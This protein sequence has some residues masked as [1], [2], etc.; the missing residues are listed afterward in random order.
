MNNNRREILK[1]VILEMKDSERK[2]SNIL[3][4]ENDCLENIPENLEGSWKY[5]KIEEAVDNLESAIS[6]IDNAIEYA[7]NATA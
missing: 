4:C 2:L 7:E 3:D 5:E 1:E 6:S